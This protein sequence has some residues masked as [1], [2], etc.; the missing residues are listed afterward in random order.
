MN[1]SGNQKGLNKEQKIG[2]ILLSCF[3][4]LA[5]TLGFLRFRDNMY[6]PFALN[7][8]IPPFLR[9]Q[10][11]TPDALRYRDTDIDGLNDFDELYVYN[12]SPYLADTDSDGI[13]DKEEIE[14]GRN[15]L[16][17]EAKNCDSTNLALNPGAV[18]TK[19]GQDALNNESNPGTLEEYLSDP[20]RLR[21]ILIASGLD[22]NLVDKFSDADLLKM[23]TEI[24][25][26]STL[27]NQPVEELSATAT[28]E[29]I[30][31]TMGVKKK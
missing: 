28:A 17:D 23:S 11:D 6:R 27:M 7:S 3:V 25:S 9:E 18:P 10:V 15:P 12:T 19:T 1:E 5:V 24:F 16:C 14:K 31:E 8:S 4:V 29:F 2:L 20:A 26:S 13:N 22:K 30:N 21:E